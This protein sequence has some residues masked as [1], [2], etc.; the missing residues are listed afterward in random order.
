MFVREGSAP[1][2][3]EVVELRVHGVG[4]APPSQLLG[5]PDPILVS[6]NVLAGF[7]R[8][9]RRVPWIGKAPWLVPP[10]HELPRESDPPADVKADPK[11]VDADEP[12][13]ESGPPADV[14]ADRES[15]GAVKLPPQRYPMEAF[16]WGGLTSGSWTRALWILLAPFAFGNAAGW[17]HE[18]NCPDEAPGSD[19]R[20][21][22]P[23]QKQMATW[24]CLTLTVAPIWMMAFLAVDLVAYRC[25]WQSFECRS[26]HSWLAAIVDWASQSHK[27]LFVNLGGVGLLFAVAILV[28]VL[29]L[30][31]LWLV[32]RASSRDYEQFNMGDPP[33]PQ[34]HNEVSLRNPHFWRS[35]RP[36]RRLQRLHLAVGVAAAQ[37][38][39]AG[40][41]IEGATDDPT[42]RRQMQVFLWLGL[43]FVAAVM[44]LTTRSSTFARDLK[45][46]PTRDLPPQ[47]TLWVAAIL[48]LVTVLFAI[49][50]PSGD[51]AGVATLD[52]CDATSCV[53]HTVLKPMGIFVR[54]GQS[55]TAVQIFLVILMLGKARGGR[56][57]RLLGALTPL[58]FSLMV[59]VP[60]LRHRGW[61]PGWVKTTGWLDQTTEAIRAS[62]GGFAYTSAVVI[63]L[64]HILLR[65]RFSVAKA[66]LGFGPSALS[67]LAAFAWGSFWAGSGALV[68]DI[69]DGDGSTVTLLPPAWF[70][71]MAT[72]FAALIVGAIAGFVGLLLFAKRPSD[73]QAVINQYPG[74]TLDD[75]RVKSIANAYRWRRI[76]ARA[77]R[78]LAFAE[79]LT[80]GLAT[81]QI[82]RFFMTGKAVGGFWLDISNFLV[83]LLPAG[84]YLGMRWAF[85]SAAGRRGVG[86]VW[87][88]VTFFPRTFHPFA[89]PCYGERA[90]PQLAFR[91]A[92]L[93][94]LDNAEAG[95]RQGV[96][97]RAHSQGTVVALAAILQAMVHPNF[98][99]DRLRFVTFG[100]PLTMLYSRV[101]P[102]YFAGLVGW[103]ARELN[104]S[105]EE[106][107]WM[108]F[109]ARTD[110]LGTKL[111]EYRDPTNPRFG[112]YPGAQDLGPIPDPLGQESILGEDG[113][114]IGG[115]STYWKHPTVDAAVAMFSGQLANDDGLTDWARAQL[116]VA[117]P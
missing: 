112:P 32:G 18:P 54:L 3:P 5:D 16:S 22:A 94:E 59:A 50:G 117:E 20:A 12:P 40:A 61:L 14:K 43:G 4:G 81:F 105:P 74:L 9:E 36:V 34:T 39:L 28:P 51:P 83:L 56:L 64:S 55:L 13:R 114:P 111:F 63:L 42:T 69:L 23:F 72:S 89:P 84:L 52:P 8:P 73:H 15:M 77:D 29:V 27:I 66:F 31:L 96:V 87:D 100:S 78:M 24:F 60:V 98:D 92:K 46:H 101:F 57:R 67:A 116:L 19:Q 76:V 33:E 25:G 58:A 95:K 71:W 48:L 30:I 1:T 85:N 110:P 86:S 10:P 7:W 2:T 106:L 17:M 79:A 108:H 107:R 41:M 80:L 45:G 88:V 38:S 91:L 49:G 104:G 90:V 115:H 102:A 82:T 75:A 65:R 21:K 6:G 99:K 11:S 103:L 26:G 113:P 62:V 93:T 68:A 109:R 44:F 35:D 37:V 47:I 53:T 70:A 97:V